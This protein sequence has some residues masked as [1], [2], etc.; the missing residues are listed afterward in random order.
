MVGCRCALLCVAAFAAGALGGEARLVWPECLVLPEG[1]KPGDTARLSFGSQQVHFRSSFESR[2][3]LK[4]VRMDSTSRLLQQVRYE[5]E[6]HAAEQRQVIDLTGRYLRLQPWHLP[7]NAGIE[8]TPYAVLS[9]RDSTVAGLSGTVDIGPVVAARVFGVPTE[10]RGGFSAWGWNDNLT[11][12]NE[13]IDA[14]YDSSHGAPGYYGG[15]LLGGS[16]RLTPHVPLY[17][18]LSAFGRSVA[19]AGEA[20][21]SAVVQYGQGVP[22]GDSLFVYMTDTV[23]DGRHASFS[24]AADGKTRYL[25]APWRIANSLVAGAGLK[26][27]ARLHLVPSLAYT[28]TQALVT[29][30]DEPNML[31]DRMNSRHS[32]CGFLETDSAFAI[33]YRAGLRFEFGAEDN[34]FRAHLSDTLTANNR[35]S[36]ATKNQDHDATGAAMEHRLAIP[37]GNNGMGVWYNYVIDR[38]SETYTNPIRV[39]TVRNY[40]DNDR[41]FQSHDAGF[42]LVDN[43]RWTGALSYTFTRQVLNYVNRRWSAQNGT[44]RTHLLQLKLSYHQDSTFQLSEVVGAEVNA[45]EWQY[46]LVHQG[47]AGAPA[48]RR[49]FT[50]VLSG[51][52]WFIEQLGVRARWDESYWDQGKWYGDAYFSTVD[53]HDT[54]RLNYYAIDRKSTQYDLSLAILAKPLE[55]M[56]FEARATFGDIYDRVFSDSTRSY[57]IRDNGIGYVL[58]PFFGFQWRLGAGLVAAAGIERYLNLKRDQHGDWSAEDRYWDARLVVGWRF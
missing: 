46:P 32:L 22:S 48:F 2:D 1:E 41:Q 8:W 51:T 56:A 5:L 53:G 26:G 50:S 13:H 10:L 31:S 34:L 20:E 3:T 30:P 12:G 17:M 35:D 23:A 27:A 52:W 43:R 19:H 14:L 18:S 44:D 15:F 54:L 4:W 38:K 40:K 55:G 47:Q 25:D 16:E 58:K 21:G 6:R 7:L 36:L 24:D 57:I 39:D 45:A 37:F 28:F 42:T 11:I 33:H 29:Y 49:T 9:E